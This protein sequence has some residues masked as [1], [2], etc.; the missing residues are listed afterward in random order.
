MSSLNKLSNKLLLLATVAAGFTLSCHHHGHRPDGVKLSQVKDSVTRL[1]AN[2]SQDISTNGPKAWLNYFEDSPDFFMA[3]NGVLSFH[4]HQSAETF[5]RDT[6]TKTI[7]KITLRWEHLRI[8][9]LSPRIASMGA[10]FHEDMVFAGGKTGAIDGYFTG[11]AMDTHKG[12]KLRNA[13]WSI[14]TNP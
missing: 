4:D 8:D 12:W 6:L 1:A 10:G 2:I 9:P 13:H 5:I 7:T 3:S 14:K 11:I